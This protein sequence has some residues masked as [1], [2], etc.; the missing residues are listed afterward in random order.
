MKAKLHSIKKRIPNMQACGF[1]MLFSMLSS[2]LA[3]CAGGQ[4]LILIK[5]DSYD[6][7]NPS[8]SKT[9]S[10]T[11]QLNLFNINNREWQYYQGIDQET[12][13]LSTDLVNPDDP[14]NGIPINGP[15]LV[16]LASLGLILLLRY[17]PK[18]N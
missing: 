14:F 10:G 4:E 6:W 1:L 8:M 17:K 5:G 7:I 12:L 9:S 11:E 16:I 18:L 3:L 2:P 13:N 15:E